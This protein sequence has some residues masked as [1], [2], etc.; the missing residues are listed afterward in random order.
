MGRQVFGR[1]YSA[2]M[3]RVVFRK[4]MAL[5]CYMFQNVGGPHHKSAGRVFYRLDVTLR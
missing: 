4:K 3:L 5:K 1:E 2:R